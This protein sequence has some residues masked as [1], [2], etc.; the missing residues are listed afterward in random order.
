MWICCVFNRCAPSRWPSASRILRSPERLCP[1]RTFANAGTLLAEGPRLIFTATVILLTPPKSFLHLWQVNLSGRSL[2]LQ[3][4][5]RMTQAES[6]AAAVDTFHFVHETSSLVCSLPSSLSAETCIK[7]NTSPCLSF[8]SCWSRLRH[9]FVTTLEWALLELERECCPFQSQHIRFRSVH[10]P[11]FPR[12]SDCAGVLRSGAARS[13]GS[14]QLPRARNIKQ[15][16]VFTKACSRE[17]RRFRF[18]KHEANWKGLG[19]FKN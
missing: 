4:S 18:H 8:K 15:V 1:A 16:S 12:L 9:S 13:L 2:A 11:G 10:F 5:V 17:H 3:D 7:L 19:T 14:S 6:V